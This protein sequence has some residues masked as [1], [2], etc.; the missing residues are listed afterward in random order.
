MPFEFVSVDLADQR[1]D[2]ERGVAAR[3]ATDARRQE[4]DRES[5]EEQL[6]SLQ[7]GRAS[8]G[9]GVIW[10]DLDHGQLNLLDLDDGGVN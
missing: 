1:L 5:G 8:A 6:R 7:R 9:P 4:Q 10:L 3:E 2:V